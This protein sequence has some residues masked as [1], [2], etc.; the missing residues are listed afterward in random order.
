M[1]SSSPYPLQ[2]Y[3]ESAFQATDII[4]N[5]PVIHESDTLTYFRFCHECSNLLYPKVDP[6][7]Q[8]L[9]DFCQTCHTTQAAVSNCVFQ[10]KVNSM[11]GATAG[12]TKD[13]ASD[14]TLPRSRTKCPRC[15]SQ[16]SVYFQSQLR[17]AD[18]GMRLY[19]VCCEC[20][21]VFEAPEKSKEEK[22]QEE[23]KRR[24]R[25]ENRER[26]KKGLPLLDEKTGDVVVDGPDLNPPPF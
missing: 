16:E 1:S 22:R 18:I 26:K 9:L 23:E 6:E 11:L 25:K 5:E 14:P 8:T 24:I 17:T 12:F 19:Y 2:D 4:S 3:D 13:V 7:S 20:G 15:P 21:T 10:N